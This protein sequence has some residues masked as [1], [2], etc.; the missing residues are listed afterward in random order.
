LAALTAHEI[1]DL[2]EK[3]ARDKTTK[4]TAVLRWV[5]SNQ[6]WLMIL[7]NVDDSA[8]VAEVAKL[9]PR[10]KGGHVIV[11][12]LGQLLRATNRLVEAE[13]SMRRAIAISETSYGPNHLKVA[14]D[15]QPRATPSGHESPRRG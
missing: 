15:Q 12:H 14:R 11:N 1:L 5:E 13:P 10:L 9:M 4:I 3:E 2:P 6:T 7:D 8:A